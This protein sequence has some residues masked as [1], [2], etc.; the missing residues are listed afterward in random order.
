MIRTENRHLRHAAPAPRADGPQRPART[1]SLGTAAAACCIS[2][3]IASCGG[4]NDTDEATEASPPSSALSAGSNRPPDSGAATT[5]AETPAPATEP[6]T[7][8]EPTHDRESMAPVDTTVFQYEAQGP[9]EFDVTSTASFRDTEF[10]RIVF[11]S[12]L[13]GDATGYLSR[14]TSDPVDVGILWAHGLPA[15]ASEAFVPMSMFACAGVTSAVVDAPYARPGAN[16][17]DEEILFTPQDRDE[18]IQLVVDMG[19]AADLLTELGAE[20]LGFQGISYGAAIGGQLLGVDDRFDAAVLLLGNGGLVDRFTDE[21]GAPSWP[22][23]DLE[24]AEV[25]AWINAMAPIE[26]IR[27]IGNS[28]ATILFMNGTDDPLIPPS[29]AERYHAAGPSGSEVHWMDAAHDIPFEEVDVHNRWLA[30]N[31]GID[32][33]RLSTCTNELFPNGWDDL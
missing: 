4:G 15:D 28:D 33:E 16:R 20:T 22:L 11:P 25:D 31:L 12:P 17:H 8:T 32:P 7:D 21:T 10:E 23:A 1:R 14:P 26:P 30:E 18:Q 19:R 29:E 2:I 13:G 3:V 24:D 9:V 5:T 27:Y 6:T